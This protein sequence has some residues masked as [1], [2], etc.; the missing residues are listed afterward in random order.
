MTLVKK[1]TVLFSYY[2]YACGVFKY[3]SCSHNTVIFNVGDIAPKGRFYALRGDFVIY[4]IW[5]AISVSKRA[6]SVSKGAISVG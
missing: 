2:R 5:G 4:Q 1:C 3:S 6:I